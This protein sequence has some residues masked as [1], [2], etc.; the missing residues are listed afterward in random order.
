MSA[1]AANSLSTQSSD[2]DHHALMF[3]TQRP[4]IVFTKGV[5]MWLYDQQDKPYLDF[6]QGW[7]VNALG[8]CSPVVID[9]LTK[10][11][12]MLINPSPGFY[13][14]PMID[15]ANFLTEKSCF[16][17]VFFANSGA[18][19]NE[20]AVKLARKWGKLNKQG[21]Y[22]IIT[23]Q[24]AFH[25]RT[26]AMMNAS[27]KPGFDEIFLPK[28]PGFVKA[29]FNDIE[30]VKPL[31]HDQTVAIMLE[32]I[33][34]EAGVI[35]ANQS[36]MQDIQALCKEHN[37]LLIVDEVQSGCGR[38]GHLFAYQHY[39]VQPHIMT[40]GKGIGAGV[41]LSACLAKQ[42][43]CLFEAGDQGGTYNGNPLMCSVG[44]AVMQTI[45]QEDFLNQIQIQANYLQS[46][47]LKLSS[48][49]GLVGER[50]LGLLRALILKSDIA[51]QLVT[52]ARERTPG[53]LINAPRPNVLRFMPALNVQKE[54]IDL[55]I[56]ALHE[57]LQHTP[58]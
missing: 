15:F 22:E 58:S 34:G 46:A 35:P 14:Q 37:L 20:S 53:I 4:D 57:L 49:H 5:G 19:A 27:G 47:L 2:I 17:R 1:Q 28:V 41:P 9:A 8:H 48:A 3:I 29:K 32:P 42:E 11:A 45:A 7:A 23:F 6:L 56:T 43:V 55:L 21:A 38:S 12:K 39:G 54:E 26:L 51:P 33:Q 24:H 16:D 36:F 25:G 50:G 31:I 30:S 18:E 10:Q 52:R 13:N 40:L 44:L